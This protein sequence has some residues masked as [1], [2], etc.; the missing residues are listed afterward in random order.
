[1]VNE[2]SIHVHLILLRNSLQALNRRIQNDFRYW[3]TFY[4]RLDNIFYFSFCIFF[5][6]IYFEVKVYWF[7]F[8]KLTFNR[9]TYADVQLC[10][11]V[12]VLLCFV[13]GDH[14]QGHQHHPTPTAQ[15]LSLLRILHMWST[16]AAKALVAELHLNLVFT[17]KHHNHNNLVITI[18]AT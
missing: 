11:Y 15:E 4:L 14:R 12:Y 3:N 8:F 7:I 18:V 6:H 13:D 1:M 9:L 16:M 10:V 2:Y 5:V 17:S